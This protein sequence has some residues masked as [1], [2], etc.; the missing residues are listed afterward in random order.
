MFF[1]KSNQRVGLDIGTHSIKLVV[2]D[3]VGGRQRI[4]KAIRQ[5]IYPD[6]EQ[7]DLDGPKRSVAVPALSE[8]F[9]KAGIN[10]RKVHNLYS[11]IGGAQVSAKEI[12]AI[13]LD[14]EEMSSAMLLEARKHIPLDGS[15]TVIDYQI[16][17]DDPKAS[18]KVRVLIAATTKKLYDAHVEILKD[19]ELKPGVLDIDQLSSINAYVI[20]RELP[21]EGV[22]VFLNL[23]CRKTNLTVI[24][25][26]DL[27]FTREIGFAGHAFTETLSKKLS[28]SY[29]QA[30]KIK[31]EQG[32][33]P[34]MTVEENNGNDEAKPLLR[35]ADK[36]AMDK[37]ADEISRSLR[38]YVKETGQSMFAK[39]VL[40]GGTAALKGLPE[41]LQE[42]F[43]ATV[44]VFDPLADSGYESN[45]QFGPQFAVAV[46][47]ALRGD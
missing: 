25:R 1:G 4:I 42:K 34:D 6:L 33:N 21:E 23:G 41:A 20:G 12:S 2:M 3:K 18:D 40:T 9:K 11:N 13:H 16:L 10:P 28:I 44:E 27:F 38:Y 7:F 29:S 5:D 19:L 15:Q 26:K 30:E 35:M 32:V 36:S 22:L 47:L 43:N 37:M 14:D 24:G 31:L 45:G 46:G 17:G 8:A 39:L